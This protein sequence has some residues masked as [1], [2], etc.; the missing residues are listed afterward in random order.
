MGSNQVTSDEVLFLHGF[1]GQ[2]SDW[3]FL[4]GNGF[5]KSFQAPSYISEPLLS[6]EVFLSDWGQNFLK[7]KNQNWGSRKLTA[8]GYSQGGRLLLQALAA[9]P[10][11]FEKLILI[12]THPGLATFNDKEAR[13]THDRKWAQKFR[14]Q[15]WEELQKE[16]DSQGVFQSK[17]G[18]VKN[19]KD[20]KREVLALCLENWSLA[21]QSNFANLLIQNSHK[22]KI[23]LGEQDSK[24]LELYQNILRDSSMLKIAKGAAHRVP[25]DQPTELV[26]I[27]NSV[28]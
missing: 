24:Y 10:D 7:W 23:I 5:S 15:N 22:V 3:D 26:E 28:I 9:A 18:P 16:W 19:E 6:P 11:M 4:K 1:W 12:S 14:N 20:F 17:P 27:L 8:V 2:S 21:H 25:F 13:L